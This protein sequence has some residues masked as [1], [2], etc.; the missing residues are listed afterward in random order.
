MLYID[1]HLQASQSQRGLS[2]HHDTTSNILIYIVK[3]HILYSHGNS[4]T[5]SA[6]KIHFRMSFS[7][8]ADPHRGKHYDP[9]LRSWKQAGSYAF[10]K[11]LYTKFSIFAGSRNRRKSIRGRGQHPGAR[12]RA[13]PPTPLALHQLQPAR[14]GKG[15]RHC[16]RDD[17]TLLIFLSEKHQ[18]DLQTLWEHITV[19]HSPK[20][21]HTD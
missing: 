15:Q 1:F 7:W 21:L 16:G 5:W 12:P 14:V 8:L 2:Y 13:L 20:R 18:E 6:K 11:S 17:G 10:R 4:A 19:G 9:G 3:S